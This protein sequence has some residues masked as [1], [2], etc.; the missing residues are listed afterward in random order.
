MPARKTWLLRLPEIQEE[1]G[2]MEVPVIDRAVFERLFGI[3]RRRAIQLMHFF[4][5]Y[6][7]GR[8]FLLD[9]VRLMGQLEPIEAGAE[10]VLEAK[11]KLRLTEALERVR[12]HRAG[13]RVV[14]P[15]DANS[16]DGKLIDLPDGIQLEPGSLHV[17]FR[18]AEELFAKLFELSKAAANDFEALGTP[19]RRDRAVW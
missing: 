14:L 4:G 17:E 11:R 9:R 2:N 5:G 15:V 16:I 7:A 12:R 13:A 6:Q 18:K 19:P 1:L 3:R 10:F 8:T